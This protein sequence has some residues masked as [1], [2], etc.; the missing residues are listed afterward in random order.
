MMDFYWL[1]DHNPL[2]SQRGEAEPGIEFMVAIASQ[3]PP[4]DLYKLNDLLI[5]VPLT[6]K[7]N[8]DIFAYYI[9]NVEL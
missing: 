3:N 6:N 5:V 8:G 1:S 4:S 2:D 9:H 7:E